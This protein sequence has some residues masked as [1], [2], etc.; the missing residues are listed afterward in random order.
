LAF[1]LGIEAKMKWGFSF[2]SITFKFFSL[3]ISGE[4]TEI[5]WHGITKTS[6]S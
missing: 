1:H 3:K 4:I 6:R 5:I 2:K